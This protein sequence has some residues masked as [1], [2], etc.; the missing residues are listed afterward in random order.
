M[1]TVQQKQKVAEYA[2][3]LTKEGQVIGLGT[4]STIALYA[5][6]LRKRIEQGEEFYAIPT[7][8]QSYNLCIENNLRITNLSEHLPEV[9][10]DGAD[11][12]NPHNHL[13]KGRGGALTQEKIVDYAAKEFYVLIDK[14]KLVVTLGTNFA[15]PIEI[16]PMSLPAVMNELEKIGKPILREAKAKDGPV[17]SDNGNFIIDLKIMINDPITLEQKLNNVPGV[18]ENGIFTRP[19]KIIITHDNIIDVK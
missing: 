10:F 15:L 11:E 2:A 5:K 17:I 16:I 3:N 13:I 4:G 9:A 14:S 8:Y 6:A 12:V 1:N 19:C 7:S 18:V